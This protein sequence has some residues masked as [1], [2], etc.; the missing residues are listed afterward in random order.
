MIKTS[1]YDFFANGKYYYYEFDNLSKH[2]LKNEIILDNILINWP[3]QSNELKSNTNLKPY[4]IDHT[5]P[6]K[7]DYREIDFSLENAN[8]RYYKNATYDKQRFAYRW[9]IFNALSNLDNFKSYYKQSVK[10]LSQDLENY[11]NYQKGTIKEKNTIKEDQIVIPVF[12]NISVESQ[13]L[14][15]SKF[16]NR[17][18]TNLLWRSI[19][20]YL[21]LQNEINQYNL[22]ENDEIVVVD[23]HK[24]NLLFTKLSLVFN[25]TEKRLIPAHKRFK[26]SYNIVNKEYYQYLISRSIE[27]T[28]NSYNE[29]L[30]YPLEGKFPE[31]KNGNWGLTE[32]NKVPKKL[33]FQNSNFNFSNKI[34]L[35]IILDK[36]VFYQSTSVPVIYGEN[37]T[38]AKGASAFS[39]LKSEGK[40]P[41]YD[42]CEALH[43]VYQKGN[44]GMNTVEYFTLIEENDRAEG[45]KII[46]GKIN[47]DLSIDKGSNY[48]QFLFRIGNKDDNAPLKANKQ[49]FNIDELLNKW[50][51]SLNPSMSPGQGRTQITISCKNNINSGSKSDK[52]FEPV[53]LDWNNLEDSKYTVAILRDEI[54]KAFPPPIN[55]VN[56]FSTDYVSTGLRESII[57]FNNGQKVWRFEINKTKWPHQYE[58]TIERFQRTNFFGNEEGHRLPNIGPNS[59]EILHEFLTNL[60]NDSSNNLRTIAWTYQGRSQKY[61]SKIID[62]TLNNVSNLDLKNEEASLLANLLEDE[63]NDDLVIVFKAC[64]KKFRRSNNGF[65][66]WL[67]FLYQILMYHEFIS[68]DKISNEECITM[69]DYLIDIYIEADKNGQPIISNN[70]LRSILFLLKRRKVFPQFCKKDASDGLYYKI[71]ALLPEEKPI[72]PFRYIH[73][74]PN[75]ALIKT[76]IDFL[77]GSGKLEGIPLD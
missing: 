26:D 25:E 56:S 48:A 50:Q 42:H 36:N 77:D 24:N 39:Q 34:K 61:F 11:F 31:F 19:S 16:K 67:R 30:Y 72:S 20:S 59:K 75:Y 51:L 47:N 35:L 27:S 41:Y 76:I 73:S 9:N 63:P 32:I 4:L 14:L 46:Q 64:L 1:I 3:S 12:D 8:A 13:E 44:E 15:L 70:A 49:Y 38:V 2:H 43:I 53:E 69:M 40:I 37:N 68:S 21:G 6:S 71:S 65:N 52:P 58:N 57:R 5:N 33:T 28:F 45:G 18:K 62:Q 60:A 55:M 7:L 23:R 17:N 29:T 54:P 66:N 10:Y 22:K 74:N